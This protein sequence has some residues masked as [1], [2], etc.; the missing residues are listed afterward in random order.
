MGVVVQNI[1]RAVASVIDSRD[2]DE[3]DRILDGIVDPAGSFY[4]FSLA[5]SLLRTGN[6]TWNKN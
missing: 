5:N 1:S 3:V 4:R 6:A 2:P